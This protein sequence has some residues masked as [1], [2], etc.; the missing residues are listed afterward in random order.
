MEILIVIELIAIAIFLIVFGSKKIEREL[1]QRSYQ[2]SWA[3]YD[4]EGD[5]AARQY[6]SASRRRLG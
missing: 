4:D 5:D 2:R 6:P 3:L 1:A